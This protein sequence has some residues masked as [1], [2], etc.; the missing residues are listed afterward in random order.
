MTQLVKELVS[1]MQC[2]KTIRTV[3]RPHHRPHSQRHLLSLSVAPHVAHICTCKTAS[4]TNNIK[5]PRSKREGGR[6][7]TP[8]QNPTH[9]VDQLSSMQLTASVTLE[10]RL[11]NAQDTIQQLQDGQAETTSCKPK[12]PATKQT[13]SWAPPHRLPS[14]STDSTDRQP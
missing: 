4:P 2:V 8:R 3:H 12:P 10:A 6:Q 11:A 7:Q 1:Y 13:P 5:Q 14:D 9:H